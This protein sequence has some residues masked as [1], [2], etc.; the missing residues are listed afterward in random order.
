MSTAV[1]LL[2]AGAVKPG[3]MKVI[4]VYHR[5]TEDQVTVSFATAPEIRQ[6]LTTGEAAD[7]VIAPQNLLD[8]LARGR[9]ISDEHLTIGRVGV[10]VLVRAAGPLPKIATV[11]EFRKSL[12]DADSIVYNQASTGIYIERLFQRL[13][14]AT[15]LQAKTTRYPDFAAVLA[16][17]G[18][19]QGNEI[20]LGA[21]TVIIENASKG[22]R[23]VGPLPE[24]IQNYTTYAAAVVAHAETRDAARALVRYLGDAAAQAIFSA[25][26]IQ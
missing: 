8:E 17:V 16:H 12:L 22:V 11:D 7:V 21:T 9:R 19:G 18:K 3:L 24:E 23:F 5:D 20:G 25:A 15:A 26:G 13:G 4:D 14:I 1:T 10:G 6:R 2:S